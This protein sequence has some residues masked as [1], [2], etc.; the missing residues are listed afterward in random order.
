MIDKNT[1]TAIEDKI[2]SFVN[3][4]VNGYSGWHMLN[5]VGERYQPAIQQVR[6][7]FLEF[8]KICFEYCRQNE[9]TSILQIGLGMSGGSHFAFKQ[10]FDRVTTIDCDPENINRY[11][12]REILIEGSQSSI[13]IDTDT[14]LTDAPSLIINGFSNDTNLVEKLKTEDRKFD[15]IFIDGDHTLNGVATDW[16]CFEPIIKLNGAICFHDHVPEPD[17][18][19]EIAVYVFLDWLKHQTFSPK[20]IVEI[21]EHLGITLYFKEEELQPYL[22]ENIRRNF[23]RMYEKDNDKGQIQLIAENYQGFN[24]LSLVDTCFYGIPQG[25]GAFDRERIEQE[26]YSAFFFGNS[27]NEI[28]TQ[29]DNRIKLVVEGYKG[30]NLLQVGEVFYGIPQGEGAFDRERI[31]QEGYSAFFFG[32]SLNEIQTQIDNHIKLVVEGYKG[33]NLLQVGKVFYGI[34]QGEGAFDRK[35]IE[36]GDYSTFFFSNSLEE[37]ENEIDKQQNNLI[38]IVKRWLTTFVINKL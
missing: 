30:F 32:N 17:R 3:L 23:V 24:I 36:Q 37:V 11:L 7:E 1:F 38:F 28:Q 33:F 21:G 14:E 13:V 29:I 10:I 26:G 4:E 22:N 2:D 19:H 8:L 15:F 9:C 6:N 25:E 20:R 27:L 12:N 31:E 35:R 16:I 5:T 18:I 34:P